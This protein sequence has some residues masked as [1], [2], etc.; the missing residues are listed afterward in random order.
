M[1]E[2]SGGT[3]TR[4]LRKESI[5]HKRKSGLVILISDK[6]EIR[7]KSEERE[8]ERKKEKE[9]REEGREGGR[10]KETLYNSEDCDSKWKCEVM[11]T[12]ISN[13]IAQL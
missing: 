11:I 3:P 8:K 5:S 6:V 9:K 4:C 2:D 1:P 10:K 13:T 7:P 12:C